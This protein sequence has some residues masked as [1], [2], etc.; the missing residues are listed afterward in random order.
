MTPTR[1]QA[2]AAA[3][4][5]VVAVVGLILDGLRAA[6]YPAVM[7]LLCGLSVLLQIR[8][9]QSMKHWTR[10][11]IIDTA[12]FI[13]LLLLGGWFMTKPDGAPVWTVP[14]TTL[15]IIV[16]A[17]PF[18]IARLVRAAFRDLQ[19]AQPSANERDHGS[20]HTT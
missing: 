11:R 1:V 15:V 12:A 3:A 8:Y 6:Y 13:V 5:V 7:A 20:G 10:R 9:P 17:M 19:A 14:V 18:A 16:A 2:I 4:L